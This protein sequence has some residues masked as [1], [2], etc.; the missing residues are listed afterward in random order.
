M[1]K[2]CSLRVLGSAVGIG[3]RPRTH[4]RTHARSHA[5]TVTRAHGPPRGA[6]QCRA[7]APLGVVDEAE[8]EPIDERAGNGAALCRGRYA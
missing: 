5:R 7:A 2:G 1:P 4:G 8:E 6:V 3:L